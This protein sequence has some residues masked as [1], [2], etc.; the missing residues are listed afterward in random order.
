LGQEEEAQGGLGGPGEE[1]GR[2]GARTET[3]GRRRAQRG[4]CHRSLSLSFFNSPRARRASARTHRGRQPGRPQ[5]DGHDVSVLCVC[6]CVCVCACVKGSCHTR[7]GGGRTKSEE[8]FAHASIRSSSKQQDSPGRFPNACAPCP[9]VRPAPPTRST[10]RVAH[11]PR[12][13]VPPLQPTRLCPPPPSNPAGRPLCPPRPSPSG[14]S[15][16]PTGRP[17]RPMS[18]PPCSSSL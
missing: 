18:C 2:A 1:G 9:P 3:A 10:V 14:P 7:A 4:G 6:V 13:P 17:G 5:G 16:S 15:W 8:K 11:A 12:S